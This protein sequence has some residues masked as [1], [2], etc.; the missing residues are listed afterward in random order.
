MSL[1]PLLLIMAAASLI[2]PARA[3]TP[4]RPP[5]VP[6]ITHDP[7]L[8]IWSE[9]DRLTDDVTRH[10]TQREHPLVSLIRI[11]GKTFRLMGNSPS[12]VPALPQTKL[13]VTPTRSTY[14]FEGAG[15]HLT[16]AFLSPLLPSDLEVLSR[17]VTYL[18][19]SVRST[20]AAEHAVAIYDS[21]SSQLTVEE[22]GERVEWKRE[23]MGPLT[24]L[25]VGTETQNY[26]GVSGDDARLNWGYAYAAANAAQSTAAVGAH[27]ELTAKFIESGALPAADDSRMP[28]AANDAQPVL[29]FAFDLGKVGATEV[30]RR[31]MVGYD[32]VYNIRFF[33][34][35]LR[36]YWRRNGAEPADLFQAADRDYD[37]LVARCAQF[38]RE[39]IADAEKVGG[40]DYGNICAL[41]YRQCLAA[42]G[43]AADSNG[44]PLFFS[45]ENS[46]NGDI[47]TTDVIF[48]GNPVLLL[49][50][51]T[52]AKATLVPILVYAAHERWKFPNAPHDLGTYPVARGTDDGGEQMPVEESGNFLIMCDAISQLEGNTQFVEPW[53]PQLTLWAK[54]LEQFGLD[55]GEQL[56]T[57]DFMGHLGHNSN[58]SLKAI[59][60]LAAYGDM[61]RLRGDQAE[62]ERYAKLA[63]DDA[64]H[65]IKVNG[66]GAHS[67]LAFD[68]PGTWSQKYNL[69]WDK[70]LGLNVF[71]KEIAAREVAF[72]KTALQPYGLPLDSRTKLSK[73]DWTIWSAALSEKQE[74]FEF[75]I[76][77]LAKYLNVTTARLPFV[78]SYTTTERGDYGMMFRARPVIGGVFIRLLMDRATWTKWASQDKTKVGGWAKL[79]PP[80]EIKEVVPTSQHSPQ[81]WRNTTE[82]P[83]E[84]WTAPDFNDR[85]WRESPAGF[86]NNGPHRT[87][88]NTS[89]IW[90]R[91]TFTMPAGDHRHLQFNVFHDEDA[92]IYVNGVLAAGSPGF[93]TSYDTLPIKPAALALLKPGATITLAVHCRQ[94]TGGQGIDVG[95]CDVT[96]KN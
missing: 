5:A 64:A 83:P 32:Q 35:D 56:C 8:S 87:D 92:Q 60:A 37:S 65:W 36:P 25:R 95:I 73:A 93:V 90:I 69:V 7:M 77:P 6:L 41:A 66:E 9:G 29:A 2:A 20:D 96:E 59:L 63:K 4:F 16:F 42:H 13:T 17:P 72:Y 26:L 18:T 94:T 86:G 51:P 49:L 53:W 21:T 28:R 52:L 40:A 68:K 50:S 61:C 74:D 54:Y 3:E 34:R 62:A 12:A 80:P 84:N 33:R 30:T 57:D 76:A 55:P 91:R 58:L 1:K 38:D 48:P 78:D 43:L 47:A 67:L 85:A 24:A 89:D 39:L 82:K 11:D 88:W 27:D 31:L 44:Q 19:W 75:I 10:W 46:S 79:P 45:K 15:V 23:T 71:P 81:L 22:R 14:E 70:I